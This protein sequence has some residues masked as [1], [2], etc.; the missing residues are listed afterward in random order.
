MVSQAESDWHVD[1]LV[2]V[3]LDC[4]RNMQESNQA[5]RC[6][7]L[8]SRSSFVP[9]GAEQMRDIYRNAGPGLLIDV[10]YQHDMASYENKVQQIYE[11]LGS[12]EKEGVSR[13]YE[14]GKSLRRL[15]M[16]MTELL[17]HSEFRFAS[18]LL[19][20]VE[21]LLWTLTAG[22]SKRVA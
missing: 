7:L 14:M 21:A 19:T 9:Q 12:L 10:L 13:S 1:S 11:T 4:Q 6:I 18:S 17:G 16:A 22:L 3:L 8:Y 2:Q 15:M 20:N 5:L